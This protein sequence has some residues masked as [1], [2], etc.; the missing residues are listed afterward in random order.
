MT[1]ESNEDKQHEN[2]LHILLRAHKRQHSYKRIQQILKSQE[3]NGLAYVLVPEQ[4][5][6]EQYPYDPQK[7]ETW[8]MIHEPESVKQFITKRNIIHFGQ[9]HGTPFT[10]PPLNNIAW[11]ADD[12]LS[13]ELING[14]V[15]AGISLQEPMVNKVLEGIAQAK[16]LP[17]IDTYI[18]TEDVAKGFR[19]WKENTSTSPSGCHLGL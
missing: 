1:Q 17:E 19:H 2:R 13:E 5:Q 9:A 14:H 15:P 6:P 8:N 3:R 16:K 7:V 12:A 4:F 10:V 18:S 11:T